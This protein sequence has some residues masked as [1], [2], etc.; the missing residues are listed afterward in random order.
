MSNNERYPLNRVRNIG[1]IA[2]IDAGKTTTTERVLYYTGM[3]HRMGEVHDGGATMDHMAQEQERGITITSAATTTFWMDHQVNIID[4]PGHIDFTAEVQ[5][6]LRVLDGG[7]T[8]FDSVAGVEPQ[9]ETVWRQAN[10]YN[11]PRICFVNKMDRVGANYERCIDMMKERLGAT[12]LPIQWPIGAEDNYRGV[13]DLIKMEAKVWDSGDLGVEAEIIPIP[14]DLVEIATL[15]REEMIEIAVEASDELMEKYLEGEDISEDELMV[16]I[17]AGTLTSQ[18]NP[19]MCGTALRNKGVQPLLDAVIHFLPSPLDVPPLVGTDPVTEED[20]V[21]KPDDKEPLAALVFKV[22]TDPYVGRLSY[23]RVYSGVL[24]T[25]TRM[26]NPVKRKTE[27]IGVVVRMFANRRENITKVQSGDIAAVLGLKHT[28]TGDTLCDPDHQVIL[29]NIEF[30]DP[31]IS[32]S[33]EPKSTKDGDKMGIALKALGEEDPTFKIESDQQTGQTV[34]FGMG[35]LH[36]E[37]LVDRMKREFNVD[38]NVGRPMVAYRETITA[39]VE[40]AEIRYKKQTGGSGQYAHVVCRFEPLEAGSGFVFEDAIRQGIIPK[41]FI[42]PVEN[43]IRQAMEAGVL[44]GFPVV[45]VKATL[46]HGSF[47]DVDSSEMS[48]KIAGQMVLKEGVRL[49]KPVILEPVMAVEVVAPED[50]SGSVM[51]SF[52]SNRG[53]VEGMEMRSDGLQSLKS[54]V[55]LSEMFGYATNLRSMTQGRGTFTMEFSHYAP[56]TKQIADEIMKR[57]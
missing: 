18:F 51:G 22:V 1:I 52:V 35:E 13:V 40:K 41:E 26:I 37:V 33:I 46:F 9:S 11:V 4:T 43:G 28:F 49:G 8:V 2:H 47:H 30:P 55:P 34:L 44:A 56:V 21:R 12:P 57:D 3:I 23:F 24:E 36:L 48:F 54:K 32:V 39:P 38:A 53:L 10:D 6:S 42:K 19:V 14:D 5:R 45:D 17:R 16:A 31:V 50:Y 20:I 7:V 29:E 25:G 15:K 27:R